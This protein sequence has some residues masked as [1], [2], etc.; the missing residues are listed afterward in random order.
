MRGHSYGAVTY[1]LDTASG[2]PC[3][4]ITVNI[5]LVSSLGRGCDGTFQDGGKKNTCLQVIVLL[6]PLWKALLFSNILHAFVNSAGQAHDTITV[7]NEVQTGL[8][9]PGS[10]V[11]IAT[12]YGLDG[13]GIESRWGRDFLHLSR[14][15]L[16][17]TQPP[18]Q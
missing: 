10:V 14:P 17:P 8:G 3:W 18:V 9:G 5:P 7:I 11:A 13:P 4:C 16:R 6:S 12:A 1:A 2:T 15:A